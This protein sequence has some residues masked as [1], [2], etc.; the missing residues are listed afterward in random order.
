MARKVTEGLPTTCCL[1]AVCAEAV[2]IP[3]PGEKRNIARQAPL[4]LAE[5]QS[6]KVLRRPKIALSLPVFSRW[7]AHIGARRM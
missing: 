1:E 4:G 6:S 5:G 2:Y 7:A 3:T